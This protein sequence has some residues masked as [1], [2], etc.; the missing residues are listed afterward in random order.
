MRYELV[1]I[2]R[3]D[4]ILNTPVPGADK[5]DWVSPYAGIRQKMESSIAN[6][7]QSRYFTANDK[8]TV[9]FTNGNM[10]LIREYISLEGAQDMKTFLLKIS[11][12]FGS[13]SKILEIYINQIDDNGIVTRID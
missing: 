8:L 7:H 1:N 3:P 13:E 5:L 4:T 12:P 10:I 11:A 6:G 2:A 9:D